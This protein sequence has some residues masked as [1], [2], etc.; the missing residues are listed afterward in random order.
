MRCFLCDAVVMRH[1]FI[2]HP[3]GQN[4]L[5]L[6]CTDKGQDRYLITDGFQLDLS[7]VF[8]TFFSPVPF[9]IIN[10]NLISEL[11]CFCFM[12]GLLGLI[13][14]SRENFMSIT[15]FEKCLLRKMV[16]C[17]VTGLPAVNVY[18]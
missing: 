13:P 3:L 9:H 7:F 10:H 16:M 18:Y 14:T 4:Q 11:L 1:L 6:I 2:G 8:S 15:P 5:V 17:S 12:Y